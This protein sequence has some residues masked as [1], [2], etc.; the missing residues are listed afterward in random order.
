MNP[1]VIARPDAR[2]PD[3]TQG[4]IALP[5]RFSEQCEEAR[6]PFASYLYI[7]KAAG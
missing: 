7:W 1:G 3:L 4:N 2:A 5:R 6:R